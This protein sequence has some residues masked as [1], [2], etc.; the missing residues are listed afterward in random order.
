MSL[1]GFGKTAAGT[2]ALDIAGHEIPVSLLAVGAAGLGVVLVLR[3]RSS[4]ANVASVGTTPAAVPTTAIDP[5]ASGLSAIS[6]AVA[7]LSNELSGL[8]GQVQGLGTPP[9]ST[10][11]GPGPFGPHS[12]GVGGSAPPVHNPNPPAPTPPSS[13]GISKGWPGSAAGSGAVAQQI[14]GNQPFG[15]HI[16]PVVHTPA[17]TAAKAVLSAVKNPSPKPAMPHTSASTS[18]QILRSWPHSPAVPHPAAVVTVAHFIKP[19]G[20]RSY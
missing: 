14:G 15:G 19:S 10:I 18:E 5:N 17:A 2:D 12:V 20:A 13:G 11:P 16:A 3:A 4:G 6:D 7:A 9:A 8:S 1:I